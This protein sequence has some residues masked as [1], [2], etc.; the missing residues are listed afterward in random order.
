MLCYGLVREFL[1][2][3]E[4]CKSFVR[5][6]NVGIEAFD[7]VL[8]RGDSKGV[9]K[10]KDTILRA[11][12]LARSLDYRI[13]VSGILGLPGTTLPQ[14]RREVDNWLSLAEEFQDVIM[15]VSVS[16][17]AVLPGSR[18]Y[19]ESFHSSSE[20]RS[21][22]G[23]LLPSLQMT[24]YYIQHNSGITF[25][26]ANAALVELGQGVIRISQNG[27]NPVKFGGYML[28]GKDDTEA[29][30]VAILNEVLDRLP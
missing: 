20:F 18:M 24:K 10:D 9:N 5:T 17:P 14:L 19:W 13:Y 6:W 3:A 11:F 28:G 2:S 23:E 30:E 1:A 22:H 21:W 29:V 16:L 4:L 27:G 15:T 26:D 12:E 25:A 7:P 8:L